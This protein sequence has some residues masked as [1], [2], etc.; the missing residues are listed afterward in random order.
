MSRAVQVG[1]D[2]QS[3][4]GAAACGARCGVGDVDQ[5]RPL[6]EDRVGQPVVLVH[7][8]ARTVH[9]PALHVVRC[10]AGVGL[11]HQRHHPAGHR[12]R[13]G[14]ARHL[15]VVFVPGVEIRVVLGQRGVVVHQAQ[16]VGARRQ[17]IRLDKALHRRSHRRPFGQEIVCQ[18]IGRIVVR[19]CP[20]GD[21][22]GHVARRADGHGVRPAIAGRG[23]DHDTRLPGL[24]HRLVHR[25]FPVEGLRWCTEGQVQHADIQ[26]VLVRH[27]PVDAPDNVGVGA[28]AGRIKSLDRHQLRVGRDPVVLVVLGLAAVGDHAGDVRTVSVVVGVRDRVL[29]LVQDGV[30]LS[31]DPPLSAGILQQRRVGPEAG[32]QYCHGHAVAR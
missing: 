20:H 23:H 12:R 11:Q 3:D 16:H 6:L 21:D 7:G 14:G 9:Q 19:H 27:R 8:D 13:L 32:V 18:V 10:Q 15:V 1:S 4:V 31:Q 2:I 22:V 26:F 28:G 29:Y 30:V 5:P 24:H 25:V 17:R